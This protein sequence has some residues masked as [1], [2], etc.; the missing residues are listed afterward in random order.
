MSAAGGTRVG[1]GQ[2]E[3]SLEQTVASLR[4]CSSERLE[5]CTW[6]HQRKGTQGLA[7]ITRGTVWSEVRDL[8]LGKLPRGLGGD[9]ETG[10]NSQ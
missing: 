2:A 6:G 5:A 4:V 7:W 10:K 3:R 9:R 1:S 8:S